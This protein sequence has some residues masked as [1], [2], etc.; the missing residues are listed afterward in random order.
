[1]RISLGRT[2][3][4]VANFV[5]SA[6]TGGAYSTDGKSGYVYGGKG[7]LDIYDKYTKGGLSKNTPGWGDAEAV[8]KQNMENKK[9]AQINREFQERMSSTAYQR[10]MADMKNAGLNPMLAYMQGGASTPSGAQATINPENQTRLADWAL[11]AYSGISTARQ[12]Q[13]QLNQQA[14][15]NESTVNLNKTAAARNIQEAE[16]TRLDNVKAKKY[17][18]LQDRGSKIIQD[19]TKTYDRIMES[20][21]TTAQKMGQYNSPAPVTAGGRQ[22]KVLGPEDQRKQNIMNFRKANKF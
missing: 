10:A 20:M 7:M 14:Q 16:K 22:I 5:V 4:D 3:D 8:K 19:A 1:M 17:E 18:P 15:M 9:E 21:A 12:Q 13:M 2:L 6:A 11:K